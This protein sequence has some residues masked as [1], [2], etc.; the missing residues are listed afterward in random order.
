M[1]IMAT[2]IA[3]SIMIASVT[4]AV[5]SL[6]VLAQKHRD[7]VIAN[8]YAMGKVEALRSKG[9]LG[10][11]A[12]TTDLTSEMPSELKSPRSATMEIS[13]ESIS[14]WHVDLSL[15]YSEHG[16]PRTLS[17][18]TLVGELGVGQY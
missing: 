18:T 14:V 10:L 6:A 13:A 5:N 12:G 17:Y 11:A 7:L 2:L 3:A 4:V 15:T 9:F 8:S 16:T 1:E